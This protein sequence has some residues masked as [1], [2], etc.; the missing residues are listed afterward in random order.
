MNDPST[1]SPPPLPLQ[2]VVVG[3]TLS[4]VE[5]TLIGQCNKPHEVSTLSRSGTPNDAL[6]LY[7]FQHMHQYIYIYIYIYYIYIYIY[8]IYIYIY[9]YIYLPPHHWTGGVGERVVAVTCCAAD[10]RVSS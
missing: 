8:T 5:T 9:I 4:F 10:I 7:I 1:P 2:D 6:V 3:N